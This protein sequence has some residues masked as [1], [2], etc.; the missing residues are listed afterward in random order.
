[1]LIK[2]REI[3]DRKEVEEI[4]SN[5]PVGRIG[6]VSDDQPYVV[7]INFVYDEGKI[8]FHSASEG[9][10]IEYLKANPNV[11]FEVDELQAIIP[12]S[13]P[14]EFKTKYRSVIALGAAKI[15][16]DK[17][18]RLQALRKIV[19]KYGGEKEALSMEMTEKYISSAGSKVEVIEIQIEELTGKKA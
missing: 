7:P 11:C 9:K 1:M 14:C 3:T 10:K 5:A 17:E 13:T 6:L 15:L 2:E 8:F 16:T 19:A 12:N 4:L 18:Q